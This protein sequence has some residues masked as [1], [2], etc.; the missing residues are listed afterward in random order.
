[1]NNYAKKYFAKFWSKETAYYNEWNIKNPSYGQC[2]I[3][4]IALQEIIGGEI[5]KIILSEGKS[6][7]FNILDGNVYDLT[8]DQFEMPV[9]YD[10]HEIVSKDYL[11]SDHRTAKRYKIF[12][13]N[14]K[15]EIDKSLAVKDIEHIAIRDPNYVAG[16]AKKPEVRIF[17]QTHK[18]FKPINDTK[19]Y[20]G[21]TVYMRWTGGPIV[22]SSTL[23]SWHS[24][25]F[26]NK[27]INH[28]RG[29]TVGSKLFGLTDYW[30]SVVKKNSGYYCVIH[31][32]TEKWLQR[33][34]YPS[35]RSYGSSWV[36]LDTIRKKIQWLSLDHEPIQQ[37]PKG[38]SIPASMRF[39]VLKR[40]S[41][42][43]QY[44]GRRAPGVELHIDHKIPW[45]KVREHRMDNLI[46]AC[47]DCNL[48]KSNREL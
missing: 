2:A 46:V 30:T 26:Q 6:H 14:L 23:V 5:A 38:R 47:A 3:S 15:Q 19:L 12:Y 1:M 45:S 40:D 11:L 21:Q 27:N 17:C 35:T 42:T 22:A 36:Y 16:S 20:P 37:K 43:C 39:L 24:G 8:S 34:L 25:I 32:E 4:A 33:L 9:K 7:Y 28:L 13:N 18:R 44:C 31:L 48:G 10:H 29:L 41:F